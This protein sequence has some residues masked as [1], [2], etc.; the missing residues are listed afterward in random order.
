MRV[1]LFSCLLHARTPATSNW[2][3]TFSFCHEWRWRWEWQHWMDVW[4]QD[5]KVKD[6]KGLDESKQMCFTDI[7]KNWF[8]ELAFRCTFI[9]EHVLFYW[10][11]LNVLKRTYVV[12]KWNN[13][14]TAAWKTR[15][16]NATKLR[17]VYLVYLGISRRGACRELNPM[18]ILSSLRRLEIRFESLQTSLMWDIVW[19]VISSPL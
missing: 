4:M 14:W 8:P 19:W 13:E 18:W 9:V 6:Q 17:L 10:T 15:E 3:I 11:C 12:N 5:K 7:S 16:K 2:V 1:L